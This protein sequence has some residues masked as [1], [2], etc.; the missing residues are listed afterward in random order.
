L[1]A[2][3]RPRLDL[4]RQAHAGVVVN[5]RDAQALAPVQRHAH[6][7]GL[8]AQGQVVAATITESPQPLSAPVETPERKVRGFGVM[9]TTAVSLAA[10]LVVAALGTFAMSRFRKGHP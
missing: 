9:G 8:N 5:R 2:K 10:I 3:Q 6:R 7:P 4:Q 1:N